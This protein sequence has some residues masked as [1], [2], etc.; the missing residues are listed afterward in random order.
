MHR[1]PKF[2][3]F[4][5]KQLG[6]INGARPTL[7]TDRRICVLSRD[8]I[9]VS[10]VRNKKIEPSRKATYVFRHER[11]HHPRLLSLPSP[12]LTRRSDTGDSYVTTNYARRYGYTRYLALTHVAC[13]WTAIAVRN[14]PAA[15]VRRTTVSFRPSTATGRQGHRLHTFAMLI[16]ENL[17]SAR[18]IR[19]ASDA[20]RFVR[21][22]IKRRSRRDCQVSLVGLANGRQET[23]F[24]RC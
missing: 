10:S 3:L 21:R 11:E 6:R 24:S 4:R 19:K 16:Y 2:F 23:R 7:A 8:D 17:W 12:H 5:F 18:W 15:E 14:R 13:C 20:E 22:A 1:R 9:F